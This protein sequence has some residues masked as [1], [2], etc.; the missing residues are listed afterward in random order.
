[1]GTRSRQRLPAR[2]GGDVGYVREGLFYRL[3]NVILEWDHPSNRTLTG[4]L[5]AFG[6]WSFHEYS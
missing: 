6:L 2:L 3:S 4:A 5:H 1:M